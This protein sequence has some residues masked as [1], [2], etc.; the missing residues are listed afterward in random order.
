VAP[1]PQGG[2]G[3]LAEIRLECLEDNAKKV[4]WQNQALNF[5]A[6]PYTLA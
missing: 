4:V 1:A 2:F 3:V 6:L 5:K